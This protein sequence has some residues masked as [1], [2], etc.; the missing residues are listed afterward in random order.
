MTDD[1]KTVQSLTQLNVYCVTGE[2]LC[3]LLGMKITE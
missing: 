3:A 1:L 2:N